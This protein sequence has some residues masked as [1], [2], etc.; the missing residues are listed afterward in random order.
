MKNSSPR[1]HLRSVLVVLALL[2]GCQSPP[3]ADAPTIE[4]QRRP[5]QGTRIEWGMVIHGGAGTIVRERLT[6][7]LEREYRTALADALRV[8][9]RVLRDGGSS[10]D[11]VIAALVP[12][13]ESP[14]FS[15]N[16]AMPFNTA[17][18]YRGWIGA[19]GAPTVAIFA[20]E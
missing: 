3:F 7:E 18:M 4:K 8:G 19:N 14:L 1:S 5:V 15:G 16:I 10:L 2:A 9:H 11:A 17:G 12:L 20:G 6:P 13:E